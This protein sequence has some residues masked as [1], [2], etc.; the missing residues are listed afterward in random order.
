MIRWIFGLCFIVIALGMII[1]HEYLSA[2]FMLM[3]VFVSFPPISDSIDSELNISVSGMVRFLLVIILLAGSF[4]VELNALVDNY[5][6]EHFKGEPNKTE[7]KS[8]VTKAGSMEGFKKINNGLIDLIRN[9]D[10]VENLQ[11][12][13]VLTKKKIGVMLQKNQIL[14]PKDITTCIKTIHGA[15]G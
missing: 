1:V 8:S 14:D 12:G 11:S 4:A 3:V 15:K 5:P 7:L 13:G 9:G 2:V 10:P 6:V